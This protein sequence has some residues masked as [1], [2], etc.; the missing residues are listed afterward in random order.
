MSGARTLPSPPPSLSLA[1]APPPRR[2]LHCTD[3]ILMVLLGRIMNTPV[4]GVVCLCVPYT[5]SPEDAPPHAD[6]EQT[7]TWRHQTATRAPAVTQDR[8]GG[9]RRHIQRL[10]TTQAHTPAKRNKEW[11]G[12]PWW[13]EKPRSAA[14]NTAPP[15]E[16]NNRIFRMDVWGWWDYS[17]DVTFDLLMAALVSP[18]RPTSPGQ[19]FSPDTSLGFV[20]LFRHH[21]TG[22]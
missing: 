16:M 8:G 15:S 12:T 9:A 1:P 7:F 22:F 5:H 10:L 18:V 3:E 19:V 21:I 6:A 14:E 17:G 13:E 2:R 11:R 4:P 20:L